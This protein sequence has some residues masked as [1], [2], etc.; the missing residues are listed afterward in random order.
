MRRASRG[1]TITRRVRSEQRDTTVP[2][3]E[4][5]IRALHVVAGFGAGG[6]E[7]VAASLLRTFD[8]EQFDV[9]AISLR[10]PFGTDTEQTLAQ[11]GIPV[12]YMGKER[13]FDP[14]VLARVARTME[15]FR[16]QVV[17][18]HT[19]AL[20]YASPYILSRRIPAMVHTVHNLAEREIDSWAGH[21]VRRIAFWRGVLPVAIAREVA[22]SVRRVYGI[23]EFP[24][25]PNGIPVDTYRGSSI[26]R[27]R[28]RNKEGFAP[29]DVLFVCVAGL[30]SQKNPALLL[31]AFYRG[32]ASDPRAHLLFV[33]RGALKSELERQIGASGLQE[34]VHLLGL[35][36]DIP[37][38]LNGTDVFVL[39]SDYEGN[40]LSVMEAMA[41]GKPMICTAVGGVPE[42]VEDGECGLLV[43]QR[44]EKALADAM[45]YMLESPEARESMGKA[46]ARRAVERF[47]LRVM[48]E[49]YENLYRTAIAKSW[50]SRKVA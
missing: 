14:L 30:R 38:I 29:T 47:D 18:T 31:E 39:S 1:G 12:W 41:A 11:D 15:H 37:E 46:S 23:D 25:I 2:R 20:L 44:S 8:R 43:P 35:R 33:G 13:G 4:R 50:P 16:P 9:G 32:P 40:P 34:R 21:L 49:A 26:D 22:D 45:R 42:L 48:T 27:E 10:G 3:E 6:A 28:W 7:R 17:H 19:Y 36:A 24:L 5:L